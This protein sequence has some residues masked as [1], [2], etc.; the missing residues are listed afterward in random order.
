LKHIELSMA[1][2]MCNVKDERPFYNMGVCE[3]RVEE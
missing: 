3:E 2:I 1:I